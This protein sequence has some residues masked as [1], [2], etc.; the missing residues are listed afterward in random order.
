MQ[1][2]FSTDLVDWAIDVL[3][4]VK[5]DLK[6]ITARVIEKAKEICFSKS[7]ALP[8]GEMLPC[9]YNETKQII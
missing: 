9:S 6:K 4:Y 7:E 3:P 8:I 2:F 5:A 1:W